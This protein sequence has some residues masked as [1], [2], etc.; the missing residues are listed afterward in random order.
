MNTDVLIIRPC[1]HFR[2]DEDLVTVRETVLRQMKEG[3]I[4]LPFGYEVV[5]MP[6]DADVRISPD[7]DERKVIH[8]ATTYICMAEKN[9]RPGEAENIAQ[10][11]YDRAYRKGYEAGKIKGKKEGEVKVKTVYETVDP[12]EDW[13]DFKG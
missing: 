13:G 3:V 11:L 6:G 4:T 12:N 8:N 7:K 1:L 5:K 2:K 9:G 10:K